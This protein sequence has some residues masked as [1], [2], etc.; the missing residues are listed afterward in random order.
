MKGKR[1][2]LACLLWITCTLVTAQVGHYTKISDRYFTTEE[3]SGLI[4]K[5]ATETV[6]QE[7]VPAS[8]F[9]SRYQEYR[10]II[11]QISR[12]L[13]ITKFRWLEK[14]ISVNPAPGTTA[15]GK[16]K[17]AYARELHRAVRD[18]LNN[19][20]EFLKT[21]SFIDET[22][23]ILL[24][25]SYITV[26]NSGNMEVVETIR[27]YNGNG[28][29][30]SGND[31]IK[32]GIRRSFPTKYV[33]KL[34]L[35][36]K[37]GF[38]VKE[39]LLNGKA[40][41][42]ELRN[43]A[44]GI[45]VYIGNSM[46][47]LDRGVFTYRITYETDRQLIFHADK[48][49]LYW[50]VNG[51]GWGFTCDK[52]SCTI[53]FPEGSK[54][55]EQACYT[56]MQGSTDKACSSGI[57]KTGEVYFQ[58]TGR[59]NPYEG[60]TVAVSI[61][62]GV[63]EQ[64]GRFSQLA[65]MAKDNAIIPALLVFM[66]LFF[67]VHFFHWRKI[68]R[69]PKSGV[70][71]PR[72]TPPSGMSAA[73]CG[74]L[75]NKEFGPH[76]FAASLVDHAVNKQVNIT[77]SKEGS[78]FKRH[79]YAFSQPS[80]NESNNGPAEEY[81]KWYGYHI[82]DLYGKKIV[83]GEYD[84]QVA[85]LYSS[86]HSNL[87]ERMLIRNGTGNSFR[88]LFSLNDRYIGIGLL[89]LFL[90]AFGSI[91][92]LSMNGNKVMVITS[93]IIFLICLAI[94]VVFMKIINAYTPEG[95]KLADEVLG[96]M[97]YLETAEERKFDKMNPPHMTLQLFEKYLPYAIALKCENEWA[98]K[99]SAIIQQAAQ[100]GYEPSYYNSS[101]GRNSGYSGIASG[102]SSGLAGTIASASTPPSSSSGGSG[103]GGS[104]GGGGGG[105]GGGGW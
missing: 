70:I 64:P 3:Y 39:V 14:G 66:I 29:Y 52:A 12:P 105:G 72:F 42:Y 103:G 57:T 46:L 77:V 87:K 89:A 37:T 80:S 25:D 67:L 32:R 54:V 4:L 93:I 95:R 2:L 50:N 81:Y 41:L 85:S 101:L 38:R 82:T 78:L 34:G 61:S 102:L 62:K 19:N 18:A 65:G 11:E 49:E 9:E 16:R 28:G 99:F 92:Y 1:I 10:E 15:F 90:V 88:G 6:V 84:S 45:D 51:T 56:G 79:A 69:D 63:L 26:M 43:A 33:N 21:I 97:M 27:I 44:N 83:S 5:S 55:L 40:E 24:F 36:S 91:I 53:R 73:D 13:I 31:E 86:L 76:L 104:S 48:D 30:N 71:I 20:P 75:V 17:E 94:Q 96:F 23:R 100:K 68:G 8:V 35:I 74:Y 98:E 59:L 60:L 58:T 22:D 7:K 47:M